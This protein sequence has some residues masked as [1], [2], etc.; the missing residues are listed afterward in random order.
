[1]RYFISLILLSTFILSSPLDRGVN[2]LSIRHTNDI[3]LL[4]QIQNSSSGDDGLTGVLDIEYEDE[5]AIY[6]ILLNSYTQ[7]NT[8]LKNRADSLSF[9]YLRDVLEKSGSNYNFTIYLGA[10]YTKWGDGG[11]EVLQNFIHSLTSNP[12]YNLSYNNKIED[13]MGID[14]KFMSIIKITRKINIFS[15]IY[16]N[17]NSNSSSLVDLESGLEY[18]QSENLSIYL[19]Y[20][21]TIINPIDEPIIKLS[22]PNQ[23]VQYINIG[24]SYNLTNRLK[25][26]L[27]TTIDGTN[28]GDKNDYSSSLIFKY[29]F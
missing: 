25:I 20:N 22:T 10:R 8:N 21:Y 14:F 26:S 13:S 11:G 17:I 2:T 4:G 18:K 19:S 29:Y 23:K 15:N 16:A 9:I 6:K 7:R 24:S 3:N 1:M 5:Y 28:F 12:K 27:E